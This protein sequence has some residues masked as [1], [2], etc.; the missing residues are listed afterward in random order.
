MR[1]LLLVVI[2]AETV[3]VGQLLGDVASHYGY[4][5]SIYRAG[6]TACEMRLD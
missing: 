4:L 6:L 1:L 3:F 5:E 2:L